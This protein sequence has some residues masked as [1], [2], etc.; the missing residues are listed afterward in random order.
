M[1]K[2]SRS[3]LLLFSAAGTALLSPIAAWAQQAPPEAGDADA[4]GTHSEDIIVTG[5]QLRGIAPTGTNVV[6][7]S[8]AQI[9]ST[10]A[11][12]TNDL[13]STIPQAGT[14]NSP[15]LISAGVNEQSTNNRPRLRNLGSPYAGGSATLV[16]I[17]GHRVVGSGIRQTTPDP[18]IVPPSVIQRVDVI[19]DGG[20]AIYGSDAVAGVI[21]FITRR[22]FKGLEVEASY[23]IGEDFRK[24][25][26]SVTAGHTW[27][28][29]SAYVAY[30]YAHNDEILGGDRD[31]IKRLNWTTGQP[32][33]RNCAPGNITVRPTGNPD[34]NFA[35]PNRT[36]GAI[37]TCDNSD[38]ATFWPSITRHSAFAGLTLD[39]LDNLRF[40]LRGF[41]THRLSRSNEGPFRTPNAAITPGNPY[42]VNIP[43]ALTS[44]AT[45]IVAFSWE[46]AFGP[47]A[48]TNDAI[49]DTWGITPSVT[50]DLS[51]RWQFRYLFNYGRSVSKRQNRALNTTLLNTY[52]AG[53]TFDTA[54]NPYDIAA[55]QNKQLLANV[56]NW[57]A[58]GEAQQEQINTRAIFDGTLFS[59]PG[60]DV[61]AA[62]GA[63]YL[64]E[65]FESRSGNGVPGFQHGLRFNGAYRNVY[66]AFG[67]IYIPIFGPDNG[68]AGMRSLDL[69]ISGR[70]DH[71]SD[72]GGT[73]NPK[74][75]ITYK[76]AEWI[77]LRGNWGKSYQAPGLS[78]SKAAITTLSIIPFPIIP[79]PYQPP[80]AGDQP[81]LAIQGGG[82]NLRPQTAKTYSFGAEIKPVEGLTA[83][84][85]YYNIDF[86]DLVDIP[87]IGDA[88]T[89]FRYYTGNF[90]MNPSEAQVAAWTAAIPAA[91]DQL[92]GAALYA[93]GKPTVYAIVNISRTNLSRVKLSGLD[94]NIGYTHETAFGSIDAGFSGNYQLSRRTQSV[95]TL[96][97]NDDLAQG[98][99]RFNFVARAGADIG[100]FRAQ[101]TLYHTAGYALNPLPANNFQ[102]RV[103]AFDVVDLFFK[104]DV[105]GEKLLKDLSLTLNINNVFD[106]APPVWQTFDFVTAGY[107]NGFTLGRVVQ[108]GARKKF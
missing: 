63:E 12:S 56:A 100:N 76:P 15:P 73:F 41:Y 61:R 58:Y 55:T 49:L 60:G 2:R 54:V 7:V 36:P 35:L 85:T 34:L 48:M 105:P 32:V 78:D 5:T 92:A 14:F 46:K 31:Y 108:F 94:F 52:L 30:N 40:D 24:F 68:G 91:A 18:D 96:P 42:Y 77:T 87:P 72:F 84:L 3:R 98:M 45:Q 9:E 26:A 83:S 27:D 57:M 86:K 19:P 44:G 25:D 17:D 97:F 8:A 39:L 43:G 104:Y 101:A 74:F 62:V 65:S 11:T 99:N 70:Y 95:V 82:T 89:F 102:S 28:D 103:G 80:T 59:M 79:N 37:N 66:S 29:G 90:I 47:A 22:D 33:D 13:L 69:S 106:A 6:G 88:A 75:G 53:T 51:S 93:P 23:G 21:N 71:Y 64:R 50:I 20:S 107:T 10:G 16:L 4:A 1:T 38:L 81:Y 67:E